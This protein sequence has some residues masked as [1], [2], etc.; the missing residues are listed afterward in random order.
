M[1]TNDA[2]KPGT[3]ETRTMMNFFINVSCVVPPN[4]RSS[5]TRDQRT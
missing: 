3:I 2:R 4:V 5:G 1:N